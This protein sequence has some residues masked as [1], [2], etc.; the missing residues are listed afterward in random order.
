MNSQNS[1]VLISK[2][3]GKPRVQVSTTLEEKKKAQRGSILFVI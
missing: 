1:I 2:S 3:T